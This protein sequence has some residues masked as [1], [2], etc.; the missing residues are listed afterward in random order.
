[1]VPAI[2]RCVPPGLTRARSQRR[3]TRLT[4]PPAMPSAVARLSNTWAMVCSGFDFAEVAGLAAAIP[5]FAPEPRIGEGF[6]LLPRP[7]RRGIRP[8]RLA[9]RV[10]LEHEGNQLAQRLARFQRLVDGALLGVVAD[11]AEQF[12]GQVELLT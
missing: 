10:G 7:H 9:D 5:L 3:S 2:V 6:Q 4:S 8:G 12:D 1:M 11:V